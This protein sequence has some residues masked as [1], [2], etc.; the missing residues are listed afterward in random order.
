LELDADAY[1]KNPQQQL[2]ETYSRFLEQVQ[3]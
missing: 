1:Y 3:E 2:V